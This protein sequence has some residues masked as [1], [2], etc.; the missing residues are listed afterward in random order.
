MNTGNSYRLKT[1]SFEQCFGLA[2]F[3]QQLDGTEY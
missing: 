3:S 1:F 2:N